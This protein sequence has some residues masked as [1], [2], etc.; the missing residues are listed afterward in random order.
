[1]NIDETQQVAFI[2]CTDLDAATNLYENLVRVDLTTMTVI[3]TDPRTTRLENGPDIVRID[4]NSAQNI[5]ILF[6]ACAA[7]ISIFAITPCHFH[8]LRNT[9]LA[10]PTHP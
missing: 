2:A 4:K 1:M 7:G 5:D 9:I 10:T 6:V 8:I 3:P